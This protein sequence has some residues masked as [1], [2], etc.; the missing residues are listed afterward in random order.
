MRGKYPLTP[1]RLYRTLLT[2]LEHREVHLT[3]QSLRDGG[4]CEWDEIFPPTNIRIKVDAN[5]GDHIE[6]VIHEIV[7]IIYLPMHLGYVDDTLEEV[8][9]VATGAYMSNYV[10]KSPKRLARWTA[11]IEKK[12]REDTTPVP[13]EE[14]VDRSKVKARD[15]R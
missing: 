9:V 8:N 11:L 3:F 2:F 13:M 4:N 10:H 15:N 14:R 5:T 1:A 12:L 6:F 7:H